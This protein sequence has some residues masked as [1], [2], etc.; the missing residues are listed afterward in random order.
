MRLFVAL[1]LPEQLRIAIAS[2][3]GAFDG[4]G[5]QAKWTPQEN[6]HVTLKFLGEVDE[7]AL[8]HVKRCVTEA[9]A[10]VEPFD[11]AVEGAGSFGRPPRVV[12][13][14][15]A[16]GAEQAASLMRKLEESL[17][18]IVKEEREPSPHMTVARVASCADSERFFQALA[19]MKAKRF[20]SFHAHCIAL[21][22]SVLTP[23]GPVY[24]TVEKFPLGVGETA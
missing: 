16:E 12:W 23:D 1:E 24:S 10:S 17:S 14:G 11:V 15:I 3:K 20:G 7:K 19:T 6:M 2:V 21:K 4:V 22:R 9:A 5:M 13:A 8:P 18:F